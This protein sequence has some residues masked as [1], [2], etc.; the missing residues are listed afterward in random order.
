MTPTQTLAALR[1]AAPPPLAD[2][3]DRNAQ[4]VMRMLQGARMTDDE[5]EA[6]QAWAV[7]LAQKAVEAAGTG[8]PRHAWRPRGKRTEEGGDESELHTRGRTFVWEVTHPT[9]L[10]AQKTVKAAIPAPLD[11]PAARAYLA[12][13]WPGLVRDAL[14]DTTHPSEGAAEEALY[15]HVDVD[16][17]AR[18]YR[19]DGHHTTEGADVDADLR[20]DTVHAE[21]VEAPVTDREIRAVVRWTYPVRFMGAQL[22]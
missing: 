15:Q 2:W 6:V 1:A 5:R 20:L 7:P 16:A 21:L 14:S 12:G 4:V 3:L 8:I 17:E 18:T 10:T 9:A 22:R 19:A 13:I 11:R